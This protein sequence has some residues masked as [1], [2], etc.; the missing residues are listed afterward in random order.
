[1]NFNGLIIGLSTFVIIGLFHPLVIKAEY[2]L[3][4]RCWPLFALAGAA[5]CAGSL[6]VANSVLAILLGVLGFS[7]FWS[8]VELFQ[9]RKRVA[10]GWFPRNPRRNPHPPTEAKNIGE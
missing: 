3:G 9:Q 5:A 6:F 10:R 7:C 2:H 4:T 1:M 8:I